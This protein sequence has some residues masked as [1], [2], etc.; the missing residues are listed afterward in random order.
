[1]VEARLVSYDDKLHRE[2]F[3]EITHEYFAWVHEQVLSIFNLEVFPNGDITGYLDKVFPE[4]TCIS[5]PH[6]EVFILEVGDQVAGMCVLKELVDGVGEIKRMYV[7][8]DYRGNAYSSLILDR[9]I[10]RAR[11]F[12]F[13]VLRLDTNKFMK[14]A[15]HIYR[16]RGFYEIG[17]YPG[18]EWEHRT[19][20]HEIM[21]FMEKKL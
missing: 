11:E 19:D 16:K 12:G 17:V 18:N 6:G 3:Y 14:A 2:S 13:K 21:V 4:Y 10:D 20:G 7:R 15:Q 5:P 1:M 9:L 8:P